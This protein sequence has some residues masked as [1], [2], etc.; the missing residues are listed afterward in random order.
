MLKSGL[1]PHVTQQHAP[2]LPG[3]RSGRYRGRVAAV[4]AREPTP[5]GHSK[6]PQ[7]FPVLAQLQI[8]VA[9]TKACLS[10]AK[11]LAV[12]TL[13]SHETQDQRLAP[14]P[15]KGCQQSIH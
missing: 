7:R 6:W 3:A 11:G 9:S 15:Y 13:W 10:K 1:T 12:L 5:H 14:R 2:G 4:D 8:T